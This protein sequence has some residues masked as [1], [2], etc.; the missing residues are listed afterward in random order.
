MFQSLLSS[1][2]WFTY[3]R[4]IY[5]LKQCKYC[6]VTMWPIL[7]PTVFLAKVAVYNVTLFGTWLGMLVHSVS[8]IMIILD[9]L[10]PPIH[11]LFLEYWGCRTFVSGW[12]VLGSVCWPHSRHQ[13][14][15]FVSCLIPESTIV[16]RI[17]WK[18][19]FLISFF[20]NFRKVLS[21]MILR[22]KSYGRVRVSA[23]KAGWVC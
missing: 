4:V 9:I 13:F 21:S 1:V 14:C 11:L 17:N 8:G 7:A 6:C 15:N 22:E 5:V 19:T 12:R 23:Y 20:R 10:S 18:T 2:A 16:G 3:G